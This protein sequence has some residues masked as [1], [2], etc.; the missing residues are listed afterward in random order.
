MRSINDADEQYE[1]CHCCSEASACT[2][3]WCMIRFGSHNYDARK[4]L[5]SE[6]HAPIFECNSQCS[7]SMETCRNRV[8][9][10]GDQSEHV[11]LFTSLDKGHGVI[12]KRSL[13][14]PG[15]FVGEYVGE[16]LS[17]IDARQRMETTKG[18][19][20]NYLLLYNEHQSNR[21]IKTFVDARY[22]GNWTRFIN[23]SCDPNL[24]V[25]PIRIDQPEPPHLAFFTRRPIEINE[26][27]SYSYG[28]QIDVNL[29]KP[30]HC[31]SSSCR[32]FMP[33]QTTD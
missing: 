4:C 7:C 13:P 10:Q 17:E 6:Q 3:C 26:E 14:Y 27:L 11:D 23:H 16:I 2:D 29:S 22:F 5:I 31:S 18:F 12:A 15:T 24:H 33:Y 25:V 32:G 19:E 9:Q 21:I 1:G 8:S 20:H 28:D 30:C